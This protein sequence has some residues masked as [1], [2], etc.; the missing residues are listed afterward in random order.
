METFPS[1]SERAEGNRPH[2]FANKWK[3]F[4]NAER[5]KLCGGREREMQSGTRRRVCVGR[6]QDETANARRN[7]TARDEMAN[8]RRNATARDEMANAHV[9]VIAQSAAAVRRNETQEGL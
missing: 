4:Q 9:A 6:R 5:C 2:F 8:A 3:R 1:N 7:A